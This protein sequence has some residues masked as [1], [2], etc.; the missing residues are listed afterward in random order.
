MTL[1]PI[2]NAA[3][4]FTSEPSA[5]VL[6]TYGDPVDEPDSE[7]SAA[8]LQVAN[9]SAF[10]DSI[11]RAG[12][13]LSVTRS[14]GGDTVTYVHATALSYSLT[15]RRP[16]RGEIERAFTPA[17][18]EPIRV[19]YPVRVLPA[20]AES[21]RHSGRGRYQGST[22]IVMRRGSDGW[23]GEGN[24]GTE[25]FGV[26]LDH[27]TSSPDGG[28]IVYFRASDLV[29]I[30]EVS[31]NNAD[32]YPCAN[33]HGRGRSQL[34]PL[35]PCIRC[36]G[37]GSDPYV[38]RG[39]SDRAMRALDAGLDAAPVI[40][41]L[42]GS[43]TGAHAADCS[44]CEV[45]PAG[46]VEHEHYF[47]LPPNAETDPSMEPADCACGMT[48]VEYDAQMGERIADELERMHASEPAHTITG[49]ESARF[50][51]AIYFGDG[52]APE[53]HED[54]SAARAR[55]LEQTFTASPA[56]EQIDVTSRGGESSEV[57]PAGGD[58]RTDDALWL[59]Q[60]HDP[61]PCPFRCPHLVSQHR[62]DV[63][64]VFC[65]CTYGR[66]AS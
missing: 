20:D 36:S 40:H 63:G 54:V 4:V 49:N 9:T 32:P 14:T 23:A 43:G 11:A 15:F 33:C 21:S 61:S 37:T 7:P 35:D 48:Y 51:V 47:P 45:E 34:A 46:E 18:P 19:G 27:S 41:D 39:L 50:D 13:H 1:E 17:T 25:R 12:F 58:T 53:R 26:R 6:E 16:N 66:P 2:S 8:P 28:R 31:Q 60:G 65:D 10:F 44:G 5:W 22:G 56:I 57:E 30:G 64:C 3:D 59:T 52:R 55:E 24:P 42:D 38:N 29:M 62:T